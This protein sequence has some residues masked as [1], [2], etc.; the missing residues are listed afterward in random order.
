M[1]ENEF[2]ALVWKLGVTAFTILV[3]TSGSCT[4]ATNRLIAN[5]HDPLTAACAMQDSTY[6]KSSCVVL[7]TRK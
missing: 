3:V 7:M 1:D 5:S 4:Y 6:Q 2:Y